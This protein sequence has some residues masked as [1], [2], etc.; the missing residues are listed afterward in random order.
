M[1]LEVNGIKPIYRGAEAYLY[2]IDW[3]GK[4]ALLKYRIPKNYR[5]SKIDTLL[6][7]R[8]TVTEARAIKEA[9]EL[10]VPAPA[11]YFVDPIEAVIVMEYLPYPSLSKLIDDNDEKGF[12]AVR[13]L[14]E[15]IAILHENGISHGDLTTSNVLVGD[16]VYLIDFGLSSLHSTEREN[17]IDI[18][19]FLRSLESTHPEHVDDLFQTLIEGY[20][21]TRGSEKTSKVLSIVNEIRLMGRY[22]AERRTLWGNV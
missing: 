9:L 10:G 6:R 22:K 11:L 16:D 17:A 20:K 21:S 2:L 12:E 15:Y 13:K 4:K 8:R 19:L 5:H 7:R 3:F 1:A 14:G 18:H